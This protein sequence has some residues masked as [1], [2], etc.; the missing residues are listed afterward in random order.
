MA[1]NET[2]EFLL[3][4]Q[5]NKII[6]GFI[7]ILFLF[8]HYVVKLRYTERRADNLS[9][10]NRFRHPKVILEGKMSNVLWNYQLPKSC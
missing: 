3:Y 8:S 6:Y 10:N 1:L 4:R 2:V 5:R 9:T 7:L